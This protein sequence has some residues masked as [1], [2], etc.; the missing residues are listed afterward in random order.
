MTFIQLIETTTTRR[1][2]LD[3]L[4]ERWRSSTEGRRTARRSTVTHD[5]DRPDT[6][7]LI[8]EFPSYEDAM[9]NSALPRPPTSPSASPNSVTA[10]RYSATST[11]NASMS[12]NRPVNQP[13]SSR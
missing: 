5:Q 8:V 13:V 3:A 6:Y 4:A 10:R 9:A 7:I 11:S 2:E 1:D 12:C